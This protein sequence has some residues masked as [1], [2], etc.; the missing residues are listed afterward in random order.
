MGT[1][2]HFIYFYSVNIFY[3]LAQRRVFTSGDNYKY[4]VLRKALADII[5]EEDNENS[6]DLMILPPES[7]VVTDEEDGVNDDLEICCLPRAVP[8]N[9]ELVTHH[10]RDEIRSP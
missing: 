2:V 1:Y 8:G 7:C 5:D 4:F 3:D 10:G 6:Y 9:V